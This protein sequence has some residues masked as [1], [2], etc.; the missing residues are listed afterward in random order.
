MSTLVI[1]PGAPKTATST[2]QQNLRTH[3]K[4][5][6]EQGVGVILP[7][8]IRGTEYLGAYLAAYRGGGSAGMSAKSRAFFDPFRRFDTIVCSEET[9][10]H[11]FMPSRKFGFGGID[12]AEASATLLAMTGI[13]TVE[14]VLTIRPQTDLLASTYSHFVHRHREA[15]TFE[16][17]LGADVDFERLLWLPAVSAFRQVFGAEAVRVLNFDPSSENGMEGFL[18]AVLAALRVSLS[19][20]EARSDTVFNPSPSARAIDLCRVMNGHIA[21]NRRS[22]LV[23]TTIVEQFP[24]AE[25]GR[26]RPDWRPSPELTA[27]FKADHE[28]ALGFA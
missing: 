16:D 25:F 13:E 19:D 11:D 17:W 18:A 27:H 3:R 2:L 10:C 4:A 20:I 7:E 28:A 14:I 5:L 1:H 8:D 22:E 23:N 21:H 26:F 24:V 6:Q 15:R 12:R 9:F